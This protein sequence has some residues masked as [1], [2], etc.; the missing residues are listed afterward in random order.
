MT[1]PERWLPVPGYGGFYDAS[2]QGRIRSLDRMVRTN[3]GAMRLSPGQILAGGTYKDGHKH[4]TLCR[5]GK[6]RTFTIH[7]VIMLTFAGP[8]PDGMEIR[9]LNGVPDD[10]R[11]APGD[12]EAQVIAAGGNLIYGTAKE[13]SED[14]DD[15]HG[16]NHEL[17]VTHCPQN[18]EYTEEN[19]YVTPNGWRQCRT[20]RDGGRPAPECSEDDC[21][22][23][24]KSRGLCG[25]HYMQ[26]QRSQLSPEKREEIKAKDRESAR[27]Y[28]E[29]QS[30]CS[31]EGDGRSSSDHVA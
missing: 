26:W 25:K 15:R 31:D 13:N 20:C 19:T 21:G 12:D 3:G 16:T 9:H 18:H 5:D 1:A 28:R 7:S 17:N 29:R 11:W 30:R 2:N 24:A 14:R 6:R 10:N 22:N 27:R 8:R 4:V 23:P